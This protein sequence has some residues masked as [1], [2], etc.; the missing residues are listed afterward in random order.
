M[1]IRAILPKWKRFESPSMKGV[2]EGEFT[3]AEI[4]NLNSDGYNIY[5]LPNFP[6]K[7]NPDKIVDGSDIDTFKSLFVDFDLKEGKYATKQDFISHLQQISQS[8]P[9]SRIVDSGN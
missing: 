8:F 1:L 5:F 7:Y 4:N 9:P 2:V 6:S 3:S